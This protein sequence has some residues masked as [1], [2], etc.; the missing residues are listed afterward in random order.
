MQD[1]GSQ[2]DNERNRRSA[3]FARE[4]LRVESA[5]HCQSVGDWRSRPARLSPPA[6]MGSFVSFEDPQNAQNKDEVSEA[7]SQFDRI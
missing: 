2:E 3:M 1:I 4:E 5:G 6:Q 7:G